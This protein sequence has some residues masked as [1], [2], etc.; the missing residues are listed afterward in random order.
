[1][2]LPTHGVLYHRC[3]PINWC[4]RFAALIMWP[5]YRHRVKVTV[6]LATDKFE[7]H[8]G[9]LETHK[10]P[11]MLRPMW[12][13]TVEVNIDHID[14][15]SLSPITTKTTSSITFGFRKARDATFFKMRFC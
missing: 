9:F 15:L 13:G 12:N 14:F 3:M 7:D 2:F 4:M 11:F 10:I 1:M 5:F 6:L 8:F